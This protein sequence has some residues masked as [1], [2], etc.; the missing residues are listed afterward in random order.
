MNIWTSL[1]LFRQP[2]EPLEPP[3]GASVYMRQIMAALNGQA[4]T[5]AGMYNGVSHAAHAARHNAGGADA[6]A[7]DAAAGTASLR[8]LGTGATQ[9]LAG[10]SD[11]AA[12]E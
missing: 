5:N 10:E 1:Q 6:L 9:A 3:P 2:N 4:V 8:T 11:V 7:S 12:H